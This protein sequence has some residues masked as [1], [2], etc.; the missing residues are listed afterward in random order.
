MLIAKGYSVRFI[1][2]SGHKFS[3]PRGAALL[4]DPSGKD[5]PACSGLV[6]VIQRTGEEISDSKADDYFGSQPMKG[7]VALPPKSLSDWKRLGMIDE[8]EYSRRRPRGLPA[9]NKGDYFHP[10]KGEAVLYRR[11]RAY[12]MELAKSCVW[13]W[14]GIVR[15]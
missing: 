2:D 4:H 3:A 15:P 1:L 9:D 13:N 14:R 10:F 8:L 6:L 11:G 7:R 5:W 12:R